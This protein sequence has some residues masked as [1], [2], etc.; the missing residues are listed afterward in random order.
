MSNK[1]TVRDFL[2]NC[3]DDTKKLA[4]QLCAVFS[5]ESLLLEGGSLTIG[6]VGE[7]GVGKSAFSEELA[8]ALVGDLS[9]VQTDDHGQFQV[10]LPDATEVSRIDISAKRL[11][12]PDY[13]PPTCPEVPRA[14]RIIEHVD[15]AP[16]IEC[17]LEIRMTFLRNG[18]PVNVCALEEALWKK[19][20]GSPDSDD[21]GDVC[22]KILTSSERQISITAISEDS[23]VPF[24]N[25]FS[26]MSL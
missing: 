24:S 9:G 23:K 5:G 17:D 3:V 13:L 20:I 16:N 22:A 4:A 2:C 19:Q 10:S 7:P 1:G 14:V 12:D 8:K 6:L 25:V 18:S 21:T 11:E 26:S 15:A